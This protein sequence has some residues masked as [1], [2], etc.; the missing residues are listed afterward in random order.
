L[1]STPFIANHISAIQSAIVQEFD[2][3]L[4]VAKLNYFKLYTTFCDI[5][6]RI[7]DAEHTKKPE[8]GKAGYA[9]HEERN[10]CSCISHR[11]LSVADK[12]REDVHYAKTMEEREL[13]RIAGRILL[14][15]LGGKELKDFVWDM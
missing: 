1:N 10:I 13:V 7:S 2:D 12:Q 14:E 5:L 4:P 11:L 3:S 8:D 6:R 15:C 9:L